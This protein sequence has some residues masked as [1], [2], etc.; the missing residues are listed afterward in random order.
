[1]TWS[2]QDMPPGHDFLIP[3]PLA[4]DRLTILSRLLPGLLSLIP[5]FESGAFRGYLL[6]LVAHPTYPDLGLLLNIVVFK[7]SNLVPPLL[8]CLITIMVFHSL[9]P[10]YREG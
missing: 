8:S 3:S 5:Y 2:L 10:L 4:P 6:Y 1:M 7:T 9:S